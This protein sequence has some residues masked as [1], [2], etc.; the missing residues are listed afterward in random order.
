MESKKNK[1]PLIEQMLKLA[2]VADVLTKKQ[3]KELVDFLVS[4]TNE[5]KKS[6]IQEFNTFAD[7][8]SQETHQRI[9][10]A[11]QIVSE[12]HA[13]ALLE[14]RQLSNK[15]KKVN[16]EILTKC[17]DLYTSLST[18]KPKDGVSPDPKEVA[19]LVVPMV[20][21]QLPEQPEQKEETG[22]DIVVKI[23]ELPTD[24]EKF[25]IDAAHI[26]NLPSFKGNPNGGGFRNLRQMHDVNTSGATDGEVLTYDSETDTWIPAA[27]GSGSSLQELTLTPALD[28]TTTVFTLSDTPTT[29]L[30][31]YLNG[32]LQTEDVD[33]TLSGTTVTFTIAP[34]SDDTILAYAG[35][36]ASAGDAVWGSITGTLSD[37]TDLQ[38]AL[39]EKNY[40]VFYTV[41]YEDADY[42]VDGTADD[43][44]INAATLAARNAGGGIVFIKPGTYY[45]TAVCLIRTGVVIQGSGRTTIIKI[46]DLALTSAFINE[47]RNTYITGT[48]ST[49]NGSPI[50]TGSGTTW[51]TSVVIPGS[52]ICIQGTYYTVLTRDSNTQ[53]TLTTNFTGTTATGGYYSLYYEQ[54]TNKN[55]ELKD[56]TIDGNVLNQYQTGTGTLAVT[57]GSVDVVGTGTTFTAPNYTGGTILII[58]GVSYSVLGDNVS[59]DNT[60]LKLTTP[61]A[62]STASGL[63]FQFIGGS[64][65]VGVFLENC[66][67]FRIEKLYVHDVKSFGIGSHQV[68]NG[69]VMNCELAGSL[70]QDGFTSY[71]DCYKLHI[72]GITSYEN[73]QSGVEVDAFDDGTA[74]HDCIIEDCICYSNGE[75]GINLDKQFQSGFAVYNCQAINNICYSNAEYGISVPQFASDCLVE[76]NTCHDN[77]LDGIVVTDNIR[78]SVIGN[79]CFDNL[80]NGIKLTFTAGNQTNDGFLVSGNRCSNSA[81]G[82]SRTQLFGILIERSWRGSVTGNTC[83]NNIRAGIR[84][85]TRADEVSVTGN[86]C[87]V[88]DE[89]GI[90]VQDGSYLSIT[91]NVCSNNSFDGIR[92]NS[93]QYNSI[94]GNTCKDNGVDAANTYSNIYIMDTF[95]SFSKY[96]SYNIISGNNCVDTAGTLLK[97]NIRIDVNND[98][99]K[100][101]NNY[102]TG[103]MTANFSDA[104]TGT[105]YLVNI[106]SS[107]GFAGTIS[108]GATSQTITLSTTATGLLSGNGTAI[109]GVTT[110]AGISSAISDETGSGSL[111]FATSPTLVTPVIGAA[112]GTSVVL[113][114]AGA[115]SSFSN[116][117]DTA[118]LQT[119]KLIGARATPTANNEIYQSFYLN[120]STGVSREIARI[121]ARA[122][123]VTNAAEQGRLVFSVISAGSFVERTILNTNTFFPTTNDTVALGLGANSWSDLFLASGGVINWNN[124]NVTLTHAANSLTVAGGKQT[125][126]ATTTTYASLNIPTGTAP[127]SP[128]DGDVWREDNTNTGLKIRVNGVT[129]TISLV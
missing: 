66:E 42:I 118:S 41:G 14:V 33:Y 101:G 95:A 40:K 26:K 44:Q 123:T 19:N 12:K 17:T 52:V 113:A 27:G 29:T 63:A 53:L 37:Q 129:K 23:N 78:P 126:A 115:I 36:T 87:C 43:V 62:G 1:N 38:A 110:S 13:D 60:H 86:T 73:E 103:A 39:D 54:W 99:N 75:S 89:R 9:L 15:Q 91:G 6:L 120:S 68:R 30:F 71:G 96:S 107:N 98:N 111:V 3:A 46:T 83:Y 24:E 64:D 28:G 10:E 76:G 104:S 56:F 67:N 85:N 108:E 119:L 94:I 112:T 77:T 121:T 79:S 125:V 105:K 21:A 69:W 72:K 90:D 97:Y 51:S 8:I 58:N 92:I 128:V 100:V 65:G 47:T 34:D 106:A 81:S 74:A 61:Y 4:L 31:L 127:T 5:Q 45:I 122:S 22:E 48:V 32:Q 116:T 55:F 109:S 35:I 114:G 70:L 59:Q 80:G 16:E 20:L 93:G 117:S 82:S 7:T 49:T 57:N 50:V 25:K 102:L 84:L 124:G 18:L 88:N 2:E 11:I